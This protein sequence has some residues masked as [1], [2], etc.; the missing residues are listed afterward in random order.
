MGYLSK[1][2]L[3]EKPAL[4]KKEFRF[5]INIETSEYVMNIDNSQTLVI[6]DY[7]RYQRIHK[8]Y[9]KNLETSGEVKKIQS[10]V[11]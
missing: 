11:E 4:I 5:T 3:T 10:G 1:P 6:Y 7:R 9:M 8:Q 2:K